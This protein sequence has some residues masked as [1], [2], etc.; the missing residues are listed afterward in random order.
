MRGKRR[1]KRPGGLYREGKIVDPPTNT[2]TGFDFGT[3]PPAR[4]QGPRER[5]C[6][7]MKCTLCIGLLGF[8]LVPF[9]TLRGQEDSA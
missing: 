7:A 6:V 3:P 1:V 5:S 2:H 4:W 9:V 8:V